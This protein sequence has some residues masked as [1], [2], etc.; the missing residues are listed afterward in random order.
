[1]GRR[2]HPGPNP[3]PSSSRYLLIYSASVFSSHFLTKS[4]MHL[5][6]LLHEVLLLDFK[7]AE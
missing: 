4:E 6:T 5:S 2:E 7:V 3:A 1:M